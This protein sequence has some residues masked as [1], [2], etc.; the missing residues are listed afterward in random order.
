MFKHFTDFNNL[1]K[2]LQHQS[3]VWKNY[4]DVMTKYEE[5]GHMQLLSVDNG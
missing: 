2:G 3:D 5:L 1:E 4:P